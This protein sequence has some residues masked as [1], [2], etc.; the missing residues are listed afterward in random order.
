MKTALITGV[1]LLVTMTDALDKKQLHSADECQNLSNGV[2]ACVNAFS[3]NDT[4]VLCRGNC[5]P[6]TLTAYYA[7]CSVSVD[8][9]TFKRRYQVLCGDDGSDGLH[10]GEIVP[11]GSNTVYNHGDDSGFDA[12][13]HDKS[14][15]EAAGSDGGVTGDNRD[16]DGGEGDGSKGSSAA[17][18]G[19]TLFTII[20]SAA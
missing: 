5:R 7:N 1:C 17:T 15:S 11:S 14:D 2:Q 6:A 10:G 20:F 12:G 13:K 3:S 19:V 4:S 8:A 16:G 18:L 9:D